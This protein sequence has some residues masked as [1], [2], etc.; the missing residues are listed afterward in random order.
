MATN[1]TVE[2]VNGT[3]ERVTRIDELIATADARPQEDRFPPYCVSWLAGHGFDDLWAQLHLQGKY[4]VEHDGRLWHH[5]GGT[6]QSRMIKRPRL[7]AATWTNGRVIT[8]VRHRGAGQELSDT[9]PQMPSQAA[10]IAHYA[11]EVVDGSGALADQPLDQRIRRRCADGSFGSRLVE[12]SALAVA[13][14]GHVFVVGRDCLKSKTHPAFDDAPAVM[15]TETWGPSGGSS[16]WI[17]MPSS[18]RD[19][20][21][22]VAAA[23]TNVWA[24][25]TAEPF[26]AHFDG[27]QWVDVAPPAGGVLD[28][29]V[30]SSGR[31]WLVAADGTL[32]RGDPAR[33][34]PVA[35]PEPVDALVVEPSSA[36]DHDVVWVQ[37]TGERA[38]MQPFAR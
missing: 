11:P 15:A 19:D 27:T 12:P 30:A 37:A 20:L 16:R 21:T 34:E 31:A 22:L 5:R 23:G 24:F 1:A 17:A 36:S 13:P 9:Y 28:L 18:V 33:F 3:P 38:W 7:Y 10:P 25:G 8:I 4:G 35:V 32:W 14:D 6:W 26:L 29:V 2:L